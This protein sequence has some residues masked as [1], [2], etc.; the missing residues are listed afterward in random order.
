LHERLRSH[1]RIPQLDVLEARWLLSTYSFTQLDVPGAIFTEGYKISNSGQIVG[2]YIDT[3]N[4]WHGFLKDGG[5]YTTIDPTGL[6]AIFTNAF[7]IN[8]AGQ[9][10]GVYR[11]SSNREH[12]FLKDGGVYTTI[13]AT[14]LGATRTLAY[15]I[16]NAGQI[17][18]L[19]DDAAGQTH[20][21][22]ED[23]GVYTTIDATPLG[24]VYTTALG[25]N[26]AGQ[27][28]GYY[29]DGSHINHGYLKDGGTYSTIDATPLGAI[30]TNAWGINAGGQIVGEYFDASNHIH[31]F[32]K[33]GGVY[34]TID[35][36]PLGATRTQARGI[37]DRGQISGIY[38]DA[39]GH[40]HAFL[41]TPNIDLA[42]TSL[43]WDTTQGGVNYAYTIS[44][45]DLPNV[46][47]GALYWST[48]SSFNAG[49]QTLIS[50]STITTATQAQPGQ[51][52]GHID[53][54]T[55]GTPADASYRY[56]LFVL[57]SDNAVSESDGPFSKDPNDV[58]SL[59][60][61]DL[62][63]LVVV[64][65]FQLNNQS[66]RFEATG[67]ILVGLRP[68]AGATFSPLIRV[69]RSVSY[70]QTTIQ[71]NG[72]IASEV[73][74]VSVPLFQGSW[75]IDVGQAVTSLLTEQAP[76]PNQFSLAGTTVTLSQFSFVEDNS[77]DHVELQGHITLPAA[78]GGIT[79]AVEDPHKIVIDQNGVSLTGGTIQLPD[80]S[81]RVKGV[82]DVE[83]E[84][85]SLEYIAGDPSAN[86][87]DTFKL[88]GKIRVP[89]VY[90]FEA[91]FVDPNYIEIVNGS[92][93]LKGSISAQDV[94]LKGGW[95]LK[96]LE[97]DFDT[98]GA[99]SGSATVQLPSH[100]AGEP[101]SSIHGELGFVVG[102]QGHGVE[103]NSLAMS[104]SDLNEAIGDSGAFLQ[105]IGGS[106]SNIAES[107]P[108]PMLFK[109]S[110]EVTVGPKIDIKLP[111]WLGGE[112]QGALVQIDASAGLD[113][114]HLAATGNVL[115]VNGLAAA[116][117]AS[118][119][120]NWNQDF[121]MGSGE[122]K[123]LGGTMDASAN[124]QTSSSLNVTMDGSA[125][126]QLP[127]IF[128]DFINRFLSNWFRI[129]GT[130]DLSY[131]NGAPLT[132]DYVEAVGTVNV[133]GYGPVTLGEHV[134]FKGNVTPIS[135]LTS[136]PP[137][138]N[139]QG[140]GAGALGS[141]QALASASP[142]K[143]A[144]QAFHVDPNTP[145]LLLTAQWA[146]IGAN[147]V[148][149]IVAPD[150][151]VYS[152]A[153]L[154]KGSPVTVLNELSGPGYESLGVLKPL[155]GNWTIRSLRAGGSGSIQLGGYVD[156]RPAR[157]ALTSLAQD[158]N[159]HGVDINYVSSV[160]DFPATVGFFY[161]D[162]PGLHAG[163]PIA[164]S[165]PVTAG[166]N[167]LVWD[168]TKVRPG[169]YY[170]YAMSADGKTPLAFSDSRSS[171]IIVVGGQTPNLPTIPR[172]SGF[173][174]GRDAFVT[175]LYN[176][177]LG[178]VPEPAGLFFWSKQLASMV[179][180]STVAR[181]FWH[182]RERKMLVSAH[183][184]LPISLRSAFK[185]ARQAWRQETRSGKSARNRRA[186]SVSGSWSYFSAAS[187]TSAGAWVAS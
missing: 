179:K 47:T 185:D 106:V 145:R 132:D 151:K 7:G 173:G 49:Q 126:I 76:L 176:E 60:Y 125:T 163:V 45:S 168:T 124:F 27:I 162:K 37:N 140:L 148:F 54:A 130:C 43:T 66:Q 175:T 177:V 52:T 55:I 56:L 6:G 156:A 92:V 64:G 97:L 22:L 2:D 127:P 138:N 128:P 83:A 101:P 139:N 158:P 74:S 104:R 133:I 102:Q 113:K 150:S 44:G 172:A 42:A 19:Y 36:T 95:S 147:P 32:L 40:F 152:T 108:T 90:N 59:P 166:P 164:S 31:G 77:G 119:E 1:A 11:D 46:A 135:S 115:V 25:I 165:V 186:L 157:T 187:E 146:N 180:P 16:N 141:V 118:A 167:H 137:G 153:K 136:A 4:Q 51:Y 71:A 149:E 38:Q 14:P 53:A 131:T 41:A 159:S 154:G 85:L 18:G 184:A 105:S 23:G 116:A 26:D 21:F 181:S 129:S 121:L 86:K 35:A 123:V 110:V 70:D 114:N 174:G 9:I 142:A 94:P 143:I 99:F 93:D 98:S 144:S 58:A 103:W 73:L 87:P 34:T 62:S 96:Q 69:D 107:D 169:L 13:D 111:S 63:P 161:T 89:A 67:T 84:S 5:G 28:V 20:G 29:Y 68:P 88:Q 10:V 122:F 160:G 48:D 183:E 80:V 112:I 82:L 178:R 120:L 91:N 17:V 3:S 61:I 15:G 75:T 182:S 39:S 171:I 33:D 57:N 78:A 109:G 134:D 8:D 117:S 155:P 12:G 30:F 50:S 65:N 72:T 100:V 24:G 79:L 81:I 170:I